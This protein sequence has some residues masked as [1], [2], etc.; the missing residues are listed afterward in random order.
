MYDNDTID[1]VDP[2]FLDGLIASKKIK[3]FLRSDG[4][5]AVDAGPLR[6][7]GGSYEGPDRRKKRA[8]FLI[9]PTPLRKPYTEAIEEPIA[10][11]AADI[12]EAMR[13]PL[14]VLDSELIVLSANKSF[15]N[16]FKVLPEETLGKYIYDLGNRQ[17]DIP[18]IRLLLGELISKDAGIDD[19]TVEHMFPDIGHKI[20]ILNARRFGPGRNMIMLAIED[21]TGRR[22]MG[23]QLE[24][25]KKRYLR[26][27]NYLKM[28]LN[29]IA[30]PVFV[31]DR[32][33]RWV[34]LNDAFCSFIGYGQDVL[35]GK[36]DYDFF[37][38]DEADIFLSKDEVVFAS[39]EE[40]L[41]EEQF[42]NAKGVVHTILTKRNLYT[43]EEGKQFIVGIIRDIT[44]RKQMEETIRHQ[45]LYDPLTDLPNR[46]LFV[47]YLTLEMAEARRNRRKLAVLFLD[48]DHFKIINDTLGHE[49]GDKLLKEVAQRL[50]SCIRESDR[51]ARLGGDEF[52]I[53]LSD[54]TYPEEAV[55]IVRKI[56]EA[57]N[58][59]YIISGH[60]LKIAF[61][62]GI[63]IYPDDGQHVEDLISNSDTAMYQAKERGRNTFRFYDPAMNVRT[64]DRA[65]LEHTLRKSIERGELVIHYQPQV[66]IATGQITCVEA[67]VRWR[68]PTLGLLPPASFLPLAEEA[69]LIVSIDSW[70]L[71]TACAQNKAWQQA[72]LPPLC[73]SVNLS[74]KQF[75][76]PDL[77]ETVSAVL[78][79]CD[80][81]PQHLALEI[82]ENTA[83]YDIESSKA[84]LL[85]LADIGVGF[86]IDDF[87]TGYTSLGWFRKLPIQKLKIDKSLIKDIGEESCNR[88]IISAII[89]LAH[90]LKLKVVAEGVE[91]EAEAAFLR[92]SGCDEM[93]GFVFSRAVTAEELMTLISH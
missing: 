53:L 25:L 41:S 61:S 29:S 60:E 90:T 36:S 30:D 35:R 75:R 28:I 82:T 48:L 57:C 6:G 89:A 84:N 59:A 72:G 24:K 17:W 50:K 78:R 62:I 34:F 63:S 49:T 91:S 26:S 79:E 77:A 39:G 12:V 74:A 33:H 47:E 43:N 38:R 3:K 86:S 13:E 68:H 19:Y 2:S 10:K 20:I 27:V 55:I 67:L 93:Q 65:L 54:I 45:A 76:Q 16:V 88:D 51:A 31:K 81:K 5:A 42:T 64:L 37:P 73:V 85:R 87:G 21:I 8:S 1:A 14:L 11:Y 32:Q 70:M 23:R 52:N 83:M 46:R 92:S 7:S 9:T 58:E 18:A 15:Y 40:N 56:L 69:G 71:R 80:L 4:W 66:V 44:K 22:A